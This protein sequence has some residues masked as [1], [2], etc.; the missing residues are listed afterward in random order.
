MEG[1]NV[2]FRRESLWI[3][4]FPEKGGNVYPVM[5]GFE[6]LSFQFWKESSKEWVDQ[7]NTESADNLNALPPKVKITMLV[8]EGE[9][10]EEDYIIETVV[11]I[12]MLRPLS[13]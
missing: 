6:R 2:L 1:E 8:K 12:K 9:S 13:F 5:S 10:G 4:E 11:E 7:W 3:D